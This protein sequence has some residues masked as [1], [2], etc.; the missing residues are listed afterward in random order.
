MKQKHGHAGGTVLRGNDGELYF[1]RDELLPALKLEGEAL[2][3]T[4]KALGLT[5]GNA[6]V[7]SSTYL[8]ADL[9]PTDPQP[10]TVHT[11][12]ASVYARKK[13]SGSTVMCPW[14]C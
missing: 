8:K 9:L 2:E 12:R 5:D 3:R 10:W 7:S 14:F 13:V 6:G 4:K 11:D 1:V